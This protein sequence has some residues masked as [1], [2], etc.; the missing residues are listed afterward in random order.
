MV[1]KSTKRLVRDSGIPSEELRER[2]P[3]GDRLG[4]GRAETSFSCMRFRP[5]TMG[6]RMLSAENSVP[7]LM[8]KA[9]SSTR[10]AAS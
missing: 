4:P 1:R 8:A 7:R 3:A 10:K 5:S 9:T 2:D 6:R